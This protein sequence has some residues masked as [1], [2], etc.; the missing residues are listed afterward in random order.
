VPEQ[1]HGAGLAAVPAGE[2]LQH[3]GAPLE[4]VQ[5]PRDRVGVVAGVLVVY[6]K[7]C[8]G[9]DAIRVGPDVSAHV[10]GAEGF[11]EG[12]VE[13]GDGQP[14][15]ELEAGL[16]V[17]GAGREP[18]VDE[19]DLDLEVVSFRWHAPRRESAG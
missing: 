13:V 5:E 14:V 15:V 4:H 12:L 3:V 18:V 1:L 2:L 10:N 16:G 17:C 8:R 19:V 9:G 7:R 6:R 11:G